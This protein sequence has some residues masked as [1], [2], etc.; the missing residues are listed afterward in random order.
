MAWQILNYSEEVLETKNTRDEIDTYFTS[1]ADNGLNV[2][3]YDEYDDNTN[4]FDAIPSGSEVRVV[5]EVIE[6]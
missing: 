2:Y 1:S 5:K 6:E 4:V 3:W